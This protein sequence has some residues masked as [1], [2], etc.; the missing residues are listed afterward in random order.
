MVVKILIVEF[1]K[2]YLTKFQSDLLN[3]LINIPE[4]GKHHYNDGDTT[5]QYFMLT[6]QYNYLDKVALENQ[7]YFAVALYWTVLIDQVCYAHFKSEYPNFKR[8][9]LYPKFIGNCT[10]PSLM[11]SEC[12]HHQHP[13]KILRA[14]NDFEDKGNRLDFDRVHFDKDFSKITR[15]KILVDKVY[16]ESKLVMEQET[17]KYFES[18]KPSVD[19]QNFWQICLSETTII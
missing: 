19:W 12:G 6:P 14:V 5:I 18:F 16:S 17:K 10:A 7:S 15:N 13:S 2:Y 1:E 3:F 8:N 9:T 11:S 4:K